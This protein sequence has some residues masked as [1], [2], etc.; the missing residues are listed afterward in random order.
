MEHNYEGYNFAVRFIM[1]AGL[2]GIFGTVAELIQV[3]K[4]FETAVETALGAA[5]QNI[6]CEDDKSA[7]TAIARLKENRAGRLTFLPVSSIREAETG[8]RKF[9]GENRDFR[10]L[11]QSVWN[12]PPR[13]GM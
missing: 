9:C 1:K 3:P 10:V 4:G 8:R 11:L 13:I 6:V 12:L 5:L 7:Q 2:P